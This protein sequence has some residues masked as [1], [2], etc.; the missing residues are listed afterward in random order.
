MDK[1]QSYT[2]RVHKVFPDLRVDT[3]TLNLEGQN[4]DILVVNDDIIFRFPKFEEGVKRLEIET[5]ILTGIQCYLTAVC[6][7]NP[8][9]VSLANTVGQAFMG[10][11]MIRGELATADDFAA[12]KQHD[13]H[14]SVAGQLATFLKEL[15]GVPITEAISINLPICD[16]HLEWS[17]TYARI[18]DRL[19]PH[20]RR[21]AQE[22]TAEHFETFLKDGRN[23]AY[24]PVMRHGDIGPGNIVVD[25][26]SWIVYGVIDFGCAGLGDPAVD[27]AW[28]QHR[29]GVGESFLKKFYAAYPE[30]ETTLERAQFY[31]GTFALREALFG[32]E[33]ND[34]E[35]L[36]RGIAT[37]A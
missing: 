5:A 24:E 11:R 30:I 8:I 32:I 23:F 33:N 21:D 1:R 4:N 3:V 12:F 9:Y 15:H 34:A 13:I 31:A 18:R 29:S 14:Q 6:V 17:G 35:A 10:Y 26:E 22:S 25:K 7:P 36:R 20:M 37:Y 16:T 27:V 28:I 19:F 2:A